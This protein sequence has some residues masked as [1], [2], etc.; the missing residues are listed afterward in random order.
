MHVHG[1][2]LPAAT[3]LTSPWAMRS[4]SARIDTAGSPGCV[5]VC[6]AACPPGCCCSSLPQTRRNCRPV[7]R[8]WPER[9]PPLAGILSSIQ[10]RKYT[11]K[12][13]TRCLPACGCAGTGPH[14]GG[15]P[16]GM[17]SADEA[18]SKIV[19]RR[20]CCTPVV[21]TMS[22]T[23]CVWRTGGPWGGSGSGTRAI[24]IQTPRHRAQRQ[25]LCTYSNSTT[26]VLVT[27]SFRGGFAAALFAPRPPHAQVGGGAAV[28]EG[29]RERPP[30][31][32][33]AA[34]TGGELMW[35]RRMP[36]RRWSPP[37]RCVSG[38]RTSPGGTA[39][40]TAAVVVTRTGVVGTLAAC[41]ARV[42]AF[43]P[44]TDALPVDGGDHL[45]QDCACRVVVERAFLQGRG[46]RQRASVQG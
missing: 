40:P 31:R 16:M 43:S 32:H 12:Y 46:R 28:A 9:W 2:G 4:I 19:V 7:G 37:R 34:A 44:F 41:R 23:F 5:L 22:E 3:C 17:S 38:M 1:P 27:T 42:R 25:E 35:S 21:R 29:R 30:W 15:V 24:A 33:A 39:G 45:D 36:R 6:A 18:R 10:P 11:H 26:K 13:H 14:K 8:R 20:A